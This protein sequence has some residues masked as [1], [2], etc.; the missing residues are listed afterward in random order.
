MQAL[1]SKAMEDKNMKEL[2][3]QRN[4]EHKMTPTEGSRKFLARWG[5]RISFVFDS[6][7]RPE[8]IAIASVSSLATL[9]VLKG[10]IFRDSF[11]ITNDIV[12]GK[13]PQAVGRCI[14]AGI[15]LTNAYLSISS[16][17][18]RSRSSNNSK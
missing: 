18:R 8:T 5:D 1:D 10:E 7:P 12:E 16:L 4:E 11:S 2:N 13:Y 15:M 9:A 6:V 17:R 14:L 3:S